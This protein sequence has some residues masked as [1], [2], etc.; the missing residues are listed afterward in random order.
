MRK[1]S[2]KNSADFYTISENFSSED[3][4]SELEPDS[5]R[6]LETPSREHKEYKIKLATDLFSCAGTAP[7]AN[8]CREKEGNCPEKKNKSRAFL[9]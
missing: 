8:R 4:N 1:E 7:P 2:H 9:A 3:R 5:P 6:T